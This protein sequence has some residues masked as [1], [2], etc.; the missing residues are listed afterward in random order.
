MMD[1]LGQAVRRAERAF[2]TLQHEVLPGALTAGP[3]HAA[4]DAAS[5]PGHRCSG[6]VALCAHG[7]CRASL[8]SLSNDVYDMLQCKAN[9]WGPRQIDGYCLGNDGC[10]SQ[11]RSER[12]LG[13]DIEVW[14]NRP[15]SCG[16]QAGLGASLCTLRA[17]RWCIA[18]RW[19]AAGLLA[20]LGRAWAPALAPHLVPYGVYYVIALLEGS[21]S[22]LQARALA[23]PRPSRERVQPTHT[24]GI[25]RALLATLFSSSARPRPHRWACA[26]VR[27]L[28]RKFE[29]ASGREKTDRTAATAPPWSP[30][31]PPP[32]PAPLPA[33]SSDSGRRERAGEGGDRG[34]A[35]WASERSFEH[36]RRRLRF[37]S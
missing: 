3:L 22:T 23:P 32:L 2:G 10:R 11:G 33:P 27:R 19:L 31:P 9:G 36:F 13:P 34:K 15:S 21:S 8:S 12:R 7:H 4:L 14:C 18:Q 29:L 16:K 6:G 24:P 17:R 25:S 26:H 35:G 37:L 20:T 30:L 28:W 5:H 1:C